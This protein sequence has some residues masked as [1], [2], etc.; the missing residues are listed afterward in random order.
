MSIIINKI[1]ARLFV[2]LII[3]ATLLIQS[4]EPQFCANCYDY[5]GIVRNKAVVICTD[6]LDELYWLMDDTESLGYRCRED[7]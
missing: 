6:N 4:C 5:S 3:F 2:I 7:W 1:K